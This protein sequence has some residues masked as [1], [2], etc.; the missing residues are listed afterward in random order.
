MR[1]PPQIITR[2]LEGEHFDM[3]QRKAL[4]LLPAETLSY[5]E[6]RD[7]LA[8]LLADREW[9][10]SKPSDSNKTEAIYE[11]ILIHH[12]SP[13]RF[14]CYARRASAVNPL[15]LAEQSA[16]ECES[17]REAADY[18]LRWELNLPGSLDGWVVE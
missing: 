7:H 17:A 16:H 12:V 6:V 1:M 18:Y 10:P 13:N 15:V 2:L 11:G 8:L 14:I 3:D 5:A 4:G 9:F